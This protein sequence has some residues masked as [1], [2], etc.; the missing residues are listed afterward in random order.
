MKKQN[1][2]LITT[3]SVKMED[4]FSAVQVKIYQ[5]NFGEFIYK[6]SYPKVGRSHFYSLCNYIDSLF[7]DQH[8]NWAELFHCQSR[9][10]EYTMPQI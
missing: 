6:P 9:G 10:E 2:T 7:N 3:L 4:G 5:N 1:N 8:P